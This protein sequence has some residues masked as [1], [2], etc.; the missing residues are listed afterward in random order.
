MENRA[1][2]LELLLRADATATTTMH[3]FPPRAASRGMHPSVTVSIG[4][5]VMAVGQAIQHTIYTTRSLKRDETAGQGIFVWC[6][7]RGNVFRIPPCVTQRP[8]D[9]KVTDSDT[10]V[11]NPVDDFS[12]RD[13]ASRQT[14]RSYP[15]AGSA[16]RG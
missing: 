14:A 12:D 7:L 9:S 16:L 4:R 10:Y 15:K 5:K 13:V 8:M 6:A 11:G 3:I 2:S 1:G